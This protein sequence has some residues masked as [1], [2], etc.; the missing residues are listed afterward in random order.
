MPGVIHSDDYMLVVEK[1]AGLLS[2]PGR[3]AENKDCLITRL[4]VDYPD[5][6]TVHRL[7]MATSGLMVFAR[8]AQSHRDLSKAFA[9]RRVA[10]RY[11]ALVVGE[12]VAQSGSVDLPLVTDWPNR[13]RQMVSHTL[14]KPSLTHWRVLARDSGRTLV[15]L[16][17]VTG[18]SHQLRV[19]MLAIGHPIIGDVFYAPP[20]VVALSRRL[21]LHA[22]TLEVPHPQTGERL[23]F[24]SKAEFI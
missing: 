9:E 23:T 14:G 19:H 6:L 16:E 21:L 11:V 2:V 7:D 3:L 1:P 15:E 20:D 10:K 13:P 17:P 12:L 22:C 8:G 18:R 4:Q 24:C 5:A